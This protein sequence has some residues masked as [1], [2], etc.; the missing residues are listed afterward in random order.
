MI[1]TWNKIVA[2]R[3]YKSEAKSLPLLLLWVCEQSWE[4]TRDPS[5]FLHCP[6]PSSVILSIEIKHPIRTVVICLGL[7][8]VRRW[9]FI[10]QARRLLPGEHHLFYK[11]LLYEGIR[12]RYTGKKEDMI[13]LFP[14]WE[15][16]GLCMR[17]IK[18]EIFAQGSTKGLGRFV[19]R[20]LG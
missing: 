16:L 17:I 11:I 18:Q 3:E 4:K 14:R 1:F 8:L 19:I 10:V 13:V 7:L 20:S 12:S 5:G 6:N 15:D 2:R 9:K